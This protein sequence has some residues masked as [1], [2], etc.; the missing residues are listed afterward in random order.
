M[1]KKLQKPS[2]IVL[3]CFPR[4]VDIFFQ[5]KPTNE[6]ESISNFNPKFLLKYLKVGFHHRKV[7]YLTIFG[8]VH[9]HKMIHSQN[10]QFA[11]FWIALDNMT[12]YLNVL[13]FQPIRKEKGKDHNKWSEIFGRKR[14][15][16]KEMW[17]LTQMCSF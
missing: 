4:I 6:A 8:K 5:V 3:V 11:I 16:S 1:S 12:R 17:N 2:E 10:Y 13:R 15:S 14:K 9:Q 7:L